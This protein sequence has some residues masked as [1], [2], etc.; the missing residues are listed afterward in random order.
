VQ[1]CSTNAHN[2]I[3]TVREAIEN[4]TEWFSA[5]D[6]ISNKDKTRLFH[7]A[8]SS[9]A[10][11]HSN[12]SALKNS[13]PFEFPESLNFLGLILDYNLKWSSYIDTLIKKLSKAV[14]AFGIKA[15]ALMPYSGLIY[16]N[17]NYGMIFWGQASSFLLTRRYSHA[18]F[19]QGYS[20]GVLLT[21]QT[22][23]FFKNG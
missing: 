8:P 1:I 14:F 10:K 11:Y 4:A 20:R 23:I 2:A 16:I 6:L 18:I 9:S 17:L 5:N 7:C 12:I 21:P 15:A 19:D 13:L 3:P 22:T